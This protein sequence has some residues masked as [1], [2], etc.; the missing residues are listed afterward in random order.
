MDSANHLEV[1]L[2]VTLLAAV[3]LQAP[4]LLLPL[5]LLSCWRGAVSQVGL[6]RS[7]V[8]TLPT[9]TQEPPRA[10]SAHAMVSAPRELLQERQTHAVGC[11]PWTWSS[12]TAWG[13]TWRLAVVRRSELL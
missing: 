7:F 8:M 6:A 1:V 13:S 11:S 3:V 4:L 10:M 9:A 2:L 5:Q 12:S